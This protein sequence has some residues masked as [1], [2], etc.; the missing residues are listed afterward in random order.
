[1]SFSVKFPALKPFY[2][3]IMVRSLQTNNQTDPQVISSL[4]RRTAVRSGAE[5]GLL[6]LKLGASDSR[7][8]STCT[9]VPLRGDNSIS[10]PLFNPGI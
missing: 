4:R 3:S 7:K 10:G 5:I 9:R 8:L 2:G 6:S 1:M